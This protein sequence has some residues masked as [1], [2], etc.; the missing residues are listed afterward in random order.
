MKAMRT[1]VAA[2][3]DSS[4][5]HSAPRPEEA[6]GRSAVPSTGGWATLS[7]KSRDH[8]ITALTSTG[9]AATSSSESAERKCLTFEVRKTGIRS[10][11][12]TRAGSF[13]N[14]QVSAKIR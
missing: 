10:L 2:A 14:G 6:A 3:G 9:R 13:G 12:G 7:T 4:R 1:W 5:K 11:R 8:E